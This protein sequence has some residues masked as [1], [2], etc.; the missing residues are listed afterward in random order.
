MDQAEPS[1]PRSKPEQNGTDRQGRPVP[2]PRAADQLF[3]LQHPVIAGYDGSS[4]SRNALCYA[5]GL[6]TRLN[7]PL[8]V[9]Y[10]CSSGVYCEPLTGQVVGV[11][12]DTEAVERWLLAELDQVTGQVDAD[13]HV[14]T[15]RGSPARELASAAAELSADALVI[16]A[17][18][19]FWHRIVG[20]VPSWLS[21][22][23]KC[24]VIVVP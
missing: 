13:V 4:S 22:H 7:R 24:P 12:R 3:K 14:R 2:Q 1:A 17:P 18:T 8:L 20:S 19:H 9:L 16:G 10:V 23:A 5:A 21:R 11:S 15:R 6:A